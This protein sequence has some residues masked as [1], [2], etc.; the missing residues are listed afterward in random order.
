M[1]HRRFVYVDDLV[2]TAALQRSGVG[3]RLLPAVRQ[4]AVALGRANLILDIGLHMA[5]AQRF[6]FRKGLLACG[7]HFV[8]QLPAAAKQG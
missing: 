4:Q 2:V 3:G 7:M 6:Y 8:E 5:L 1:I